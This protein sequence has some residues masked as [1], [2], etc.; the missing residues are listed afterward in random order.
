MRKFSRVSLSEGGLPRA[1]ARDVA[2]EEDTIDFFCF[3]GVLRS[4]DDR[5][6]S[7]G[8]ST[9]WRSADASIEYERDL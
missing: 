8:A 7:V 2:D 6:R 3:C 1:A 5:R 4:L 9:F